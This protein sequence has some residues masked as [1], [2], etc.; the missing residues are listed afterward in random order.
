MRSIVFLSSS[1]GFKDW[2]CAVAANA[3]AKLMFKIAVTEMPAKTRLIFK[4][5]SMSLAAQFCKGHSPLAAAP[6]RS[7]KYESNDVK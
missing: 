7:S 6:L 5:P 3:E 2:S 4:T 1:L